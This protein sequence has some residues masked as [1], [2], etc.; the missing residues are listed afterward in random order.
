[1]NAINTS[2]EMGESVKQA[3]AGMCCK[4]ERP[5]GEKWVAVKRLVRGKAG[6]GRKGPGGRRSL[7]GSRKSPLVQ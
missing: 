4:I 6:Q 5:D 7:T 1:M 3:E 2:A